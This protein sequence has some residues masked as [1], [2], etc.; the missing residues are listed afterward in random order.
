MN[1]RTPEY[2]NTVFQEKDLAEIVRLQKSQ[3][4]QEIRL[5][6]QKLVADSLE[7]G[8]V[9]KDIVADVKDYS[10]KNSLSEHEIATIVS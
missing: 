4:S 6:L 3:A 5:A 1:K 9:A 2:F 8:K 7:E 10:I